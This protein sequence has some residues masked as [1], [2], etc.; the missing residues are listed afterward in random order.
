MSQIKLSRILSKH[1]F[2]K[3]VEKYIAVEETEESQLNSILHGSE[4]KTIEVEKTKLTTSKT[5]IAEYYGI[6]RP[7]LY[8]WMHKNGYS[9]LIENEPKQFER[10][11]KRRKKM[12]G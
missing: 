3:F 9:F 4:I 8:S 5:N 2:R 1:S 12:S 11:R 10:T 7:T 6:S